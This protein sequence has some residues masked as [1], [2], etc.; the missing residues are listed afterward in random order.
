MSNLTLGSLFDGSGGFPLA[1]MMAGITPIW[2]SEIEPF[3]IRVTTKR[4]PQMKHYGDISKM[5]G[6][7]IEPVDIITFGSPCQ[8]LS[9]AGKREGLNGEKSSMFFEAIRVIKEMRESTNGEYPRWIVWE[10]VPG[11][12]SSSKGQDFRTVLEEICKI[13]DE[14]VHI[15]MPEKKWTTAG[16]IVGND[17]SVA[18]RI[19]DAQYFGVPQRRR[20]IFL[21][22]DFAGECAGKVLFESESVFGNFKKSLCS[23][24]GTAGTAETGIGET[25]TI[26][27][28]DQGGERID[29]TQDKTTTLRAQA[30]HPPCVM[31]ENHSQDTRYIGPL[32]VSQTVF[33]TFGTGGN[34][35]P[36]VVHTPKTLKIRCG[37]DGGGKGALI[38]ENKSATLSCNNDQTLFEPKVYGICSNDSNSM[39][40]DN[41]NSGIYAADTSR[42]IDCGGVNPSSNQGG[43]AVVAL[44][45]SIIGRKEKNGPNGSGFNQ[46]TSFTLNT[47]DRHAVAYGIDRAAFNQ[48]QNALYD[49]A[50]EKEKQPTMVAKGPGAVAE[51]AYS[52]SKASF[53]TSAEK[54][55]ANTLVASDYKDPPLVNDTNG[56]EYIVRRLT[57]KECALLQG[58]PVWWCDGLKTENPTEEEIQKWSDIFENHRKALCKST[59]PKTRNQIIKWLKNPHSDRAEYTMWG[60]GV[61]L[62]CV[63]Y[64]LN[65][66]AHYAELTNSVI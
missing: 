7:K 50:I 66:I 55:C 8:N 56:T 22:A 42:T 11:A 58:F 51:P 10:N 60:N 65:G 3:P 6:G 21:V 48:G 34:N 31:F 25:G 52:A 14:T 28:N 23:W 27:L 37:C 13:K 19:L 46:D 29:V 17:Y 16:E 41:P 20:R 9:L 63:F 24:Q 40:S 18:Y 15:P 4:I 36:F 43:M 44:Q 12:M 64:V 47:V 30:H 39:K 38:Q 26:C 57:P 54:E 5:N 45:G 53:F 1:G 35:Q 61:A 2:A 62:P 59:K 49:F 32:E 33:A